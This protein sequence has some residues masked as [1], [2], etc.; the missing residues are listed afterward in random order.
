MTTFKFYNNNQLLKTIQEDFIT[1]EEITKIKSELENKYQVDITPKQVMTIYQV[2]NYGFNSAFTDNEIEI[3]GLD[4][5]FNFD[6]VIKDQPSRNNI[7][8]SLSLFNNIKDF[9][10][11]NNIKQIIN[12]TCYNYYYSFDMI[13]MFFNNYL[14]LIDAKNVYN[15]LTGY[16]CYQ[17]KYSESK[18]KKLYCQDYNHA[19][20]YDYDKMLKWLYNN[21]K[22]FTDKAL[23]LRYESGCYRNLY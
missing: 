1:D 6:K 15:L 19:F 9:L 21:H 22:N 3:T 5:T 23:Q 17:S 18:N 11:D 7:C 20:S 8:N 16:K 2:L 13:K 4:N 10:T 14:H 12:T